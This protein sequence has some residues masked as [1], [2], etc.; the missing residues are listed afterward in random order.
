MQQILPWLPIGMIHPNGT[1]ERATRIKILKGIETLNSN[2]HT[3]Q[4]QSSSTKCF[5]HFVTCFELV[6]YH[7][8]KSLQVRNPMG[9]H[10]AKL[11]LVVEML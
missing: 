6:L 1:K 4:Q 3:S 9:M 7:K 8:C 5:Y 2:S 10:L 11:L